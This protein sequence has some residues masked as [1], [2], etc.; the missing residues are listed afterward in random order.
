MGRKSR[1][2]FTDNYNSLH[3]TMHDKEKPTYRAIEAVIMI[4]KNSSDK[5]FLKAMYDTITQDR[6]K[7]KSVELAYL[8]DHICQ[9]LMKTK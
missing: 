9:A 3:Q 5:N 8:Y 6:D 7:Y 1:I 4:T 2:C